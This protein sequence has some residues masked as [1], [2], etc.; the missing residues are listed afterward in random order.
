MKN[1]RL[2]IINNSL[3]GYIYQNSI[4]TENTDFTDSLREK[5]IIGES[6]SEDILNLFGKPTG[7]I[8][9]P[10]NLINYSLGIN[11][12]KMLPEAKKAWVYSLGYFDDV[13]NAPKPFYKY[14]IFFLDNNQ[15]VVDKYYLSN[16]VKPFYRPKVSE[17]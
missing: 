1:L 5:I 9:I 17:N 16:I 15:L 10:T 11:S 14:L 2:E 12:I 4:E 6:N 3:N 7:L 13:Y 8:S